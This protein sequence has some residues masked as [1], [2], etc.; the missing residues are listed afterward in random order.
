[1]LLQANNLSSQI[2]IPLTLSLQTHNKISIR[3]DTEEA[4]NIYQ[5]ITDLSEYMHEKLKEFG[6]RFNS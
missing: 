1:M 6:V 3:G 5:I 2:D 4:E